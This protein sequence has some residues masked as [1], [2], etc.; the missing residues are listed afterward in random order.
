MH[1]MR[2]TRCLRQSSCSNVSCAK[3][4]KYVLKTCLR[5][6]MQCN[7]GTAAPALAAAEHGRCHASSRD[8]QS[9]LMRIVSLL[10]AQVASS[11]PGWG[12]HFDSP[13]QV[14]PR[15]SPW[16]VL[17]ALS[18]PTCS[19]QWESQDTSPRNTSIRPWG[20]RLQS[21]HP[22]TLSIFVSQAQATIPC[23]PLL[24]FWW[25]LLSLCQQPGCAP[26]EQAS[27][28]TIWAASGSK[29]MPTRNHVE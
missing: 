2:Q 13:S 4:A 20:R 27:S 1:S 14:A 8:V 19:F 16:D 29:P 26:Y 7:L 9:G 25:Q 23:L 17:Q 12:L 21:M 18:W 11:L 15:S 5:S 3:Y 10:L 6:F 24:W 28:T 22:D